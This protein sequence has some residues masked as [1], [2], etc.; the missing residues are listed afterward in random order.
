MKA[1]VV[2]THVNRLMDDI[3]ANAPQTEMLQLFLYEPNVYIAHDPRQEIRFW[4]QRCL[5]YRR[6]Q[7]VI[8]GKDEGHRC[9]QRC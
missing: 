8:I 4:L 2:S 9:L 1:V 5:E 6:A 3:L 7:H